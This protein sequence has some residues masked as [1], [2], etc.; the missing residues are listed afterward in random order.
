MQKLCKY[1]LLIISIS[2][3]IGLLCKRHFRRNIFFFSGN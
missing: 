2:Y 1:L 3:I